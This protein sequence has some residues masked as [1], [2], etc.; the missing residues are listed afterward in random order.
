M[1]QSYPTIHHFL[2]ALACAASPL[3]SQST[4]RVLQMTAPA[5]LG[6][7]A[8]FELS[9]PSTATGNLY[10][11]FWC[12]PPSVGIYPLQLPGFQVF[13]NLQVDPSRQFSAFQGWLDASGLMTHQLTI[14]ATPMLVGVAMDLQTADLDLPGSSVWLADHKLSFTISFPLAPLDNMVPIA[15]GT[16]QRGNQLLPFTR[17]VHQVTIT[18][19]F[20]IGR[21]EL[22]QAEYEAVMGSNPSFFR[23]PNRPVENVTWQAAQAYCSALTAREAL[24]GRLPAGYVYRLP[25]EAEWEYACRA[26]TTTNFYFGNSITC[27]E[28]N[29]YSTILWDHC[30]GSTRIVGSYPGNS[31][32]LHETHG[33]VWEWCLDR[34]DGSTGYQ[35]G[36]VADP[37]LAVGP[38]PIIRGG[39]YGM[40]DEMGASW[41]RYT[42]NTADRG[43][44]FRVVCA[45]P[46]VASQ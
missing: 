42:S 39:A 12:A 32:G 18:R 21:Y 6:G 15:P 28:V 37:Y 8:R 30:V 7:Q 5:T 40:Y 27:N 45:P 34:W 20:W 4:G 11:F 9:H 10:S 38:E 19:P 24:A 17:P 26:G 14:P 43:I 22:T 36:A 46:A 41:Y 23:G 29:H 16:Y 31:W 2:L 3:L 25:T 1:M 44:G 13:G 33:N 35:P